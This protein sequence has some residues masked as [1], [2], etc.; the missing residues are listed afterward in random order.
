M[1]QRRIINSNIVQDAGREQYSNELEQNIQTQP[2]KFENSSL[3]SAVQP[4]KDQRVSISGSMVFEIN[5]FDFLKNY[6][7]IIKTKNSFGLF[8]K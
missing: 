1:R 5:F 3:L 7:Y 2:T 4:F 6:L 8:W